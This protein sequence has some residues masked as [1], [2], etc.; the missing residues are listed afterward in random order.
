MW[1]LQWW[2]RAACCT[3]LRIIRARCRSSSAAQV[4][5]R[6]AELI[7][8]SGVAILATIHALAR[9]RAPMN[10][11]MPRCAGAASAAV[12]H[13]LAGWRFDA[14]AASAG[15][16]A[17][18]GELSPGR[19]GQLPGAGAGGSFSAYRVAVLLY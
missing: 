18:V 14:A 15:G 7:R 13:A 6:V 2:Q 19:S 17:G 3:R 8:V 11:G 10:D 1:A 12:H 9:R 4:E 5:A 16:S